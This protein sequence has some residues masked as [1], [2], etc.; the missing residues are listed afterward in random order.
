MV[1]HSLCCSVSSKVRTFDSK[2]E[3]LNI[4]GQCVCGGGES[5]HGRK[6]ARKAPAESGVCLMRCPVS[7]TAALLPL[8]IVR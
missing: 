6:G 3:G 7:V 2:E 4:E 8:G 5:F 1:S